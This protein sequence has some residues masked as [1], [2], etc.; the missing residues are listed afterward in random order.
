MKHWSLTRKILVPTLLA[1]TV[2][3][4]FLLWIVS[5]STH[6]NIID[7]ELANA[8]ATIAQFKILRGYYTENVVSKLKGRPDL[9]ISFDH[10]GKPDVIPLPASMI[11]DLSKL[12]GQDSSG[13]FLKLYSSHPFPNRKDRVLDG[14]MQEAI[15]TLQRDPH[16]VFVRIEGEGKNQMMRVAIADHMVKQA[17]V[18]C[19]NAHPLSPKKDW[20]LG[21]VRGILEVDKPLRAQMEASRA[22]FWNILLIFSG[23]MGCLI[24]LVVVLTRYAVI[25]PLLKYSRNLRTAEEQVAA[26]SEHVSL[27]SQSLAEGSGTQASSLEE[28]AASL[29]ELSSMTRRNSDSAREADAMAGEASSDVEAGK[30]AMDRMGEAIGRIKQSADQTARIIR[31]IDEIAFQ[32]NLLALNAAVEAARAGESGKGFAVVAEEVR[33]LAQRSAEAAK[34]TASLIE[35][36]QKNA[37]M[38]VAV[39]SEVAAALV[40]SVDKV[41]RLGQIIEEVSSASQEQ[42]RGLSQIGSAMTRMDRVTQANAASS[43]ESAAASEELFAQAKELGEMVKVLVGIV[44]GTSKTWATPMEKTPTRVEK[45]VEQDWSPRPPARTPSHV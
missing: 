16:G 29:E 30:Q 15:E 18:D 17:C 9:K 3:F 2:S 12:L 34:N 23:C 42:N 27:S 10:A 4:T 36:S 14:F 13:V 28:T 6:R 39:S 7:A 31:T 37:D 43:E 40:R 20:K 33:A 21:D 24:A 5:R 38:G 32:T 22:L 45:P 41:K 35:E 8:K 44:K 26:A 11:H 25:K 1:L 19:H